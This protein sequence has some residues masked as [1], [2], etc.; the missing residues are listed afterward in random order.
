MGLVH[1]WVDAPHALRPFPVDHTALLLTANKVHMEETN[2][3][4]YQS[5]VRNYKLKLILKKIII[6]ELKY[7]RFLKSIEMLA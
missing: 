7:R 2:R 6:R 5:E 1:L 4:H 3:N